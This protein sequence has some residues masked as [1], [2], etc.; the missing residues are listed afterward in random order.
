MHMILL[1]LVLTHYQRVTDGQT[2]TLPMP[3]SHSSI[4]ECDRK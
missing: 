2:D 1:S 3:M 4:A